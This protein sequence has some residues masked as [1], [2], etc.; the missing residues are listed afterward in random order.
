MH[1]RS[2]LLLSIAKS[3]NRIM[4][5]PEPLKESNIEPKNRITD[6]QTNAKASDCKQR[7]NTMA[8]E[9]DQLQVWLTQHSPY[10]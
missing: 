7:N 2:E 10:T 6:I 8:E 5:E 1:K 9:H 3:P 4:K